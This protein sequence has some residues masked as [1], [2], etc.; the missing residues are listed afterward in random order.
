VLAKTWWKICKSL[1]IICNKF[2]KA[3]WT[4]DKANGY[5]QIQKQS[6]WIQLYKN[7]GH[8]VTRPFIQFCDIIYRM[9]FQLVKHLLLML[10]TPKNTLHHVSYSFPWPLFTSTSFQ[11]ANPNSKIQSKTNPHGFQNMRILVHNSSE[12]I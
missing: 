1:K 11:D 3:I 5:E 4:I 6:P 9:T 12:C 7:D 10:I 8:S 2:F